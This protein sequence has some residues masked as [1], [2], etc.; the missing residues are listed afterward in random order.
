MTTAL[1][2]HAEGKVVVPA[3]PSILF[4][5]LDDHRRLSAHMQRRSPWM[6]GT[7]MAVSTDD[8]DGWRVGSHIRL[9]GAVL[10]IPLSVDEVVEVHEIPWRK[11]W[12]TVDDVRLLVIGAYRMGFAIAPAGAASQ[13]TVFIDYRLPDSVWGRVA[14]AVLGGF[15]ARWCVGMMLDDARRAMS[16]R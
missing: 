9:E 11:T 12:V 10:G 3:D 1:P 13:L 4:A 7:R 16:A 8:G 2:R 14:G 15:Y 6:L 5:H